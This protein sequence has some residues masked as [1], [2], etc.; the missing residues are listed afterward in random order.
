MYRCDLACLAWIVNSLD[1]VIVDITVA[2]PQP[3]HGIK[4]EHCSLQYVNKI[5]KFKCL[6]KRLYSAINRCACIGGQQ[7]VSRWCY[8]SIR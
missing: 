1:V 4:S 5:Y 8:K 3:R 7:K 2:K 6:V